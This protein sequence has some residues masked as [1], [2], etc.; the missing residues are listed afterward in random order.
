MHIRPMVPDDAA[1]VAAIYNHYVLH[2]VVTFE[3]EAVAAGEMARRLGRVAVRYPWLVG[4]AEG[5]IVGYAYADLFKN[6][7][8]YRF[9]AET[10][11]YLRPDMTGKGNGRLLYAHLLS[12]LEERGIVN[13]VAII[14]LPNPASIRLHERTGFRR[15]GRLL[16]VGRKFGRWLDVEYWQRAVGR[17]SGGGRFRG[18]G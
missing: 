3:E 7:S 14:A 12:A 6:R 11:V 9:T 1:A 15:A 2:T 13:A 10:T 17:P 5:E 8:A 4:E 18:D 16:G